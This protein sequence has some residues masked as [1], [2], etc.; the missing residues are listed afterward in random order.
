MRVAEGEKGD[1]LKSS[2]LAEMRKKQSAC[3][4]D[5]PVRKLVSFQYPAAQKRRHIETGHV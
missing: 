3:I 1:H 5:D 2:C 4:R